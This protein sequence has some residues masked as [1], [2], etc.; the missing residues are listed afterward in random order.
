MN[1]KLFSNTVFS[2]TLLSS[3]KLFAIEKSSATT[4]S[5]H[6]ELLQ[7][8]KSLVKKCAIMT[9]SHTTDRNLVKGFESQCSTLILKSDFQAQVFIEDSWYTATIIE[10]QASDDGDLDDL[11]VTDSSGSIVAIR[12]NV[13]AFDNIILAMT[14]GDQKLQVKIIP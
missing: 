3:S 10:S 8:I 4:N 5:L 1:Y 6:A 13:S 14:G 9:I 2:L 11:Q 12:K 7:D